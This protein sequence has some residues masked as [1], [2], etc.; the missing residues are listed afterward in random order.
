MENEMTNLPFDQ[1]L[2]EEIQGWYQL[3]I[4]VSLYKASV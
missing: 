4:L 3:D 1:I 2:E